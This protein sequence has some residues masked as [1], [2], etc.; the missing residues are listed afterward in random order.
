MIPADQLADLWHRH[1]RTLELF[2]ATR[3]AEPEDCVQEAFIQLGSATPVPDEPV[4]WLY[5]VVRNQAINRSRSAR[6]RRRHHEQ[7]MLLVPR[8]SVAPDEQLAW[9]QLCQQVSRAVGQLDD[10]QRE[11]V[12]AHAW[13]GLTFRQ[14]ADLIGVSHAAAHRRYQQALEHIRAAL[15]FPQSD[16]LEDCHGYRS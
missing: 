11:I 9:K 16:R 12:I 2:A 5:R 3:C 10:D 4:A 15:P 7:S 1:A 6:R 13:G 14:I 8:E